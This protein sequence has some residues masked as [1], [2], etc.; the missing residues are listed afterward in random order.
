MNLLCHRI[1]ATAVGTVSLVASDVSHAKS[2]LSLANRC[3]DL[4]Q[5]VR[6]DKIPSGA[7]LC[8]RPHGKVEVNTVFGEAGQSFGQWV[9]SSQ[10][11]LFNEPIGFG[12]CRVRDE[13]ESSAIRL[14]CT[15]IAGKFFNGVWIR[16][17][18]NW[19]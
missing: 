11:I 10:Q 18:R 17:R 6:K 14:T 4:L 15:K 12:T 16:R 5:P 13:G 19:G 9:P 1:F 3:Y 8:F 2:T 7:S